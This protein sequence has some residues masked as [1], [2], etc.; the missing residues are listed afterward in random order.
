MYRTG[1]VISSNTTSADLSPCGLDPATASATAGRVAS[2]ALAAGRPVSGAIG[3]AG[4][5]WPAFPWTGPVEAAAGED[6]AAG[7]AGVAGPWPHAARASPATV[8]SPAA[9]VHRAAPT[10]CR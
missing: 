10:G 3:R 2:A 1:V 7:F 9:A 8:A 6:T 4:L 5:P